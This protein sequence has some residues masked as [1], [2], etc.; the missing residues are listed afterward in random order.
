YVEAVGRYAEEVGNLAWAAPQDWMCE[1]APALPFIPVL[2]GWQLQD[3]LAGAA[4][5]EAASIELAGMPLVGLWSVCRRQ[6][7]AEV[8][9]IVG[10]LAGM[11]L[12]L[13][14][15]GMKRRGLAAYSGN[16]ISA[17]SLAW[18]YYAR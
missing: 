6:H 8:G 11:G 14:G 1:L 15:F 5:Y 12:R 7:T 2:Q 9:R 10:T 3:Y 13:H 4:L 16:L 17:D 18:S